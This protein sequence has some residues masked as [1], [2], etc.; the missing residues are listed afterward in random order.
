MALG[1]E[2]ITGNE[3]MK[4]VIPFVSFQEGQSFEMFQFIPGIFQWGEPKNVSHLLP[5]EISGIC[6]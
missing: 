5:N 6:D 4:H 2:K 1:L 3:Q